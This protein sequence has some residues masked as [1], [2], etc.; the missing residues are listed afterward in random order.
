MVLLYSR[1]NFV[2]IMGKTE[3]WKIAVSIV[4]GW[5]VLHFVKEAIAE[6]AGAMIS[7]IRDLTSGSGTIVAITG[8]LGIAAIIIACAS[9]RIFLDN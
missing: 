2:I 7:T 3:T 5:L 8:S 9:K 6:F 1:C 4:V